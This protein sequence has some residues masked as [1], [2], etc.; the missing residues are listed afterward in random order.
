MNVGRVLGIGG[1]SVT[2]HALRTDPVEI[3]RDCRV[4]RLGL[5]FPTF[6]TGH[7]PLTKP[8]GHGVNEPNRL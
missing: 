4:F 2:V 3:Y 6:T 8:L 5:H 7:A 1:V